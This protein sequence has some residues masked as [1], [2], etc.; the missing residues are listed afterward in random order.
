MT[1]VLE[2]GVHSTFHTSAGDV[3]G[4][5]EQGAAVR[6]VGRHSGCSEVKT[7]SDVFADCFRVHVTRD[8]CSTPH[9]QSAR[10]VANVAL[11]FTS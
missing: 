8:Q 2:E 4:M 11:S 5:R 3:A 9:H 10:P 7:K 1:S 6:E